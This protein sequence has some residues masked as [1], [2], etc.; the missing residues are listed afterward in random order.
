MKMNRA[1]GGV[2]ASF[3]LAAACWAQPTTTVR[4][5]ADQPKGEVGSLLYGQFA[6]FMFEDVRGGLYAELL[7]DRGFE[8]APNHLGLP[9]YWERDPDDRN[10][11]AAL[12]FAWD[13]KVSY[14][15]LKPYRTDAPEHSLK[16]SLG[17]NGG[18]R[19]GIRQSGVP[20]R[21]GV[22]YHGYVWVRSE[23]FHGGL[24]AAL[25]ADQTGGE[26]YASSQVA[27][28]D[29]KSDWSK[30]EFTLTPPKSD[31]LAKLALLLEGEGT[32]YLDQASLLPA[33]AVGGV[34][35]DVLARIKDLHPAFVRWPGGNV[36]QDYWWTWGVGPRDQRK[37]WVNLAWG[38]EPEPSDFGTDEYLAFCREIGAVP[39][40]TVNVEGGGASTELAAAW[41][42]YCNG[43]AS[44]KYGA[45]RAANGHPEPYH[46]RYWEVG[47]E[48]WGPWV[49]GHSD[50]QTYAANFLRYARAMKAVDPDIVL[51]GCGDNSMDWNRTVLSKA[52]R[53][54]DFF[55]VHH[56]YGPAEMKGD[57]RNLQARPL[58]YERFYQELGELIARLVPGKTLPLAI[59]EWNTTLAVPAQHS[60]QSALYAGRLMNVFVRS[61][62][63]VAMSCVS[64]LV[65]GW[66]GGV[67]QASRAGRLHHPHGAGERALRRPPRR[68][69]A[70]PG[71]SRSDL[72]QQPGGK[73]RSRARCGRHRL[74]RWKPDLPAGRQQRSATGHARQLAGGGGA[75]ATGRAPGDGERAHP[76]RGQH[77]RLSRYGA[78]GHHQR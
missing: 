35:A 55:A 59:N 17:P 12:V 27:R 37:T 64:D 24:R 62:G 5:W 49:R 10:D 16:I 21:A 74:R 2:L 67:I 47:N 36:A 33:D 75:G 28:L 53:E 29:G 14:P 26:T 77:L 6:E 72:Q 41:V 68:P 57:D 18:E 32:L 38:N 30:L 42:E 22:A 44:S 1:I 71:G 76:D 66:S 69:R 48:I 19:R 9:R 8:G 3:L 63:L 60:M 7:R 52:G 54:M 23:D 43:P 11:D 34:R 20:V 73:R 65:N 78:P 40:L 58:H 13:E 46:V 15:P 31:P 4:V 61:G 39:T 51:I 25:E 70:G 56:Y 45:M 50:A